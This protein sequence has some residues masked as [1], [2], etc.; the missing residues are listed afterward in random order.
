MVNA[1]FHYVKP[2]KL[3]ML[4]KVPD[5]PTAV[6]GIIAKC[7][8]ADKQERYQDAQKL[9]HELIEVFE[10]LERE[11]AEESQKSP[12]KDVP[13][14]K[15]FKDYNVSEVFQLVYDISEGFHE[16]AHKMKVNGI[17]GQYFL[18]MLTVDDEDMTTSIA[19]GGLGFRK[20]Q[21]KSAK[22]AIKKLE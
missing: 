9:F 1:I 2:R 16:I 21:L 17:N 14:P 7:L 13:P 18:D 5:V 15:P 20:L 6:N 10:E 8:S 22:A 12:S 4:D 3:P 19:D 11:K